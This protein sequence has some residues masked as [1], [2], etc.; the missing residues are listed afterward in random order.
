MAGF[1]I[2]LL[3]IFSSPGITASTF[4]PTPEEAALLTKN[5]PGAK[6]DLSAL[7]PHTEAGRTF[8]EIDD[9]RYP[10]EAVGI[11]NAFT[12]N[13]WPGG[14]LYY[15]FDSAVT[16]THRTAWRNAAAAWSAVA[17]VSFTESTGNGNYVRVQNSSGN[18][19]YIGM[20]GGS[21]SMNIAD[22]GYR[23]VIAHEIGHALGLIH[24][25]E[26][27]NR[28]NYINIL[29]ANIQ[30]GMES[31]FDLE[32][33]SVSYGVYD[34]DSVMHYRRNDFSRNGQNTIEPK[35]PYWNYLYTMGQ[36]DHLSSQDISGMVQ[37]YGGSGGGSPPNNNFANRQTLTGSG[38]SVSGSSV[39]ATSE[40]GEPNHVGFSPSASVWYSWTAPTGSNV[41]IDTIGSDFD[42]LLAVYTGYSLGTLTPVASNDDIPGSVQSRV[43]FFAMA[44]QTYQ[45]AVDGY[46]GASGN[47]VL[48]W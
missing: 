27:S 47:I 3:F 5:R 45:I 37:R 42:T 34:F 22:W 4:S 8:F 14:V 11:N 23:Y 48:N 31:N 21:Q 15:Q 2:I 12:G 1:A 17:S 7:T 36:S 25:H 20:I 29:Y 24:E 43:T 39:G 32:S 6:L 10:A 16:S 41:T 38:G 30:S 33:G 35:P 26:R 19:S 28:D 18:S 46:N 9:M 13:R 44:G 40:A